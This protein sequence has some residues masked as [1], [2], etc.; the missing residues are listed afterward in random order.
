MNRQQD[1]ATDFIPGLMS[2]YVNLSKAQ[3]ASIVFRILVVVQFVIACV[4][5]PIILVSV[6]VTSGPISLEFLLTL[7]SVIT[8]FVALGMFWR[9]YD[10]L[11]HFAL[12]SG[13]LREPPEAVKRELVNGL[14]PKLCD[15]GLAGDQLVVSVNVRD[16]GSGPRAL[17]ASGRYHLLL[18][19]GFLNLLKSRP[20]SA[21]AM[22]CHELGHF[23]QH[24]TRRW[25]LPKAYFEVMAKAIPVFALIAALQTINRLRQTSLS[26]SLLTNLVAFTVAILTATGITVAVGLFNLFQLRKMRRLSEENSDAIGSLFVD[27]AEIGTILPSDTVS[28][29]FNI[30]SPHP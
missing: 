8:V 21:Q 26:D 1:D 10:R 19:L 24:D 20:S 6:L 4:V 25:G 23:Y 9:R 14:R 27:S 11:R 18:A 2:L 16:H 3:S 5:N 12:Q 28:S 22:L 17:E 7:V 30:F 15:L 29:R 13:K